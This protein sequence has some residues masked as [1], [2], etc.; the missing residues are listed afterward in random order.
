MQP[1]TWKAIGEYS[2]KL[3][4]AVGPLIGVLVG[5]WLS[6]G[7]DTEKWYQENRKQECR[8]LLASISHAATVVLNVGH[9]NSVHEA[10]QAYL[11]SIKIFQ[12]RIFIAGDIEKAKLLD[13]WAHAVGD[14][15]NEKIDPG[16][17]SDRLD[18]IRNTIIN[19]VVQR[20]S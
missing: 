12:D 19:L 17:F 6:R 1:E 2:G 7:W 20:K 9:G 16:A 18:E 13:A 4:T 8:E 11:D 3:W 10:N 5:A 14:V 15:R